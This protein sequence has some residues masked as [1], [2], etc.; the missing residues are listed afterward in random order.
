MRR[1]SFGT[2]KVDRDRFDVI[3]GGFVIN[4]EGFDKK[5]GRVASRVMRKFE[6]IGKPI[7]GT[8]DENKRVK[9]EL[10]DDGGDVLLEEA[11]ITLLKEK[12][13]K[14]RFVGDTVHKQTDALDWLDEIKEE[15]LPK[16]PKEE[17]AE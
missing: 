10:G 15:K 6:E 5:E 14:V 3:Y 7:G 12:L 16:A 2:E 8:V 9:F 1:L 17:V 13:E 11:E 4:P